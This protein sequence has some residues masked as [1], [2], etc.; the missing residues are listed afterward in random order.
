MNKQASG[1]FQSL[2]EQLLSVRDAER[3][4]R[5]DPRLVEVN[6]AAAGLN[7]TIPSE[8][9]FLVQSDFSNAMLTATAGASLLMQRCKRVPVSPGKKGLKAPIVDET[10]RATGSRWGGVRVYR[11]SE[12]DQATASKPKVALLDMELQKLIGVCYATE[13]LFEDAL[14]LDRFITEAFSEEFAFSID[15]EIVNGTGAGEMLGILNASCLVTV[16]KEAGQTKSILSSNIAKMY[17]RMPARNKQRAVWL[18][19]DSPD[20]WNHLASLGTFMEGVLI[21]EAP[22]LE[23][24]WGTLFGRPILPLEQCPALGSEGDIIF[25]DLSQYVIAER[26]VQKTVSIH[27]RYIFD[28]MAFKFVLRNNGQPI[29]PRARTPYVGSDSQAP[30]VT[31]AARA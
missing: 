7:E 21:F 20:T 2:G 14:V 24:P 6:R 8:G 27:V 9:N 11:K 3:S 12:A 30:F 29:W 25:A 23:A 4:G 26:E 22:S 15:N 13:E 31:L 5:P 18:V 19:N 16:A 17:A 28:E 1:P 10:S